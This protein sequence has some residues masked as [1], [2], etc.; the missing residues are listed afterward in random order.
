MFRKFA[1]ITLCFCLLFSFVTVPSVA[2]SSYTGA[3]NWALAELG[4]ADTQGLIP[5]VMKDG[6]F[7]FSNEIS[8][9]DFCKAVVL[10]YDQLGGE[11]NL[12][13]SNPFSDITD[14]DVIKAFNAGIIKGKSSDRFAPDDALTRQEM[15]VMLERALTAAK[16]S[17]YVPKKGFQNAYADV[18]DIAPWALSAVESMNAYKII[19]GTSDQWLSPTDHLTGE[20]AIVMMYR[21]FTAFSGGTIV[22]DDSF[23]IE[24]GVLKKCIGLGDVVIPNTVT[25]IDENVFQNFSGLTSITIPGTVKEIP[26]EAF[27]DCPDL[28]TVILQEGVETIGAWSFA[29]C[30]KLEKVTLPGSVKTIDEGAFNNCTSLSAI[31]F[32]E[33]L[34]SIGNTCFRDVSLTDVVLPASLNS[35]GDEA[36]YLC[37]KLKNVTFK[38]DTVSIGDYA[39]DEVNEDMVI[40]CGSGSTAE[41]YAD[42]NGLN[43]VVQ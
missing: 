20:Q 22:Q 8:R 7:N 10:F 5:A 21:S 13:Q 9:E 43:K 38:S 1:A 15:C 32:N 27:R 35:I 40:H 42:E 37:K 14:A 16:V 11:Q 2:G 18:K 19:N 34:Q 33:G 31:T 41:A 12:P 25:S 26:S 28:K 6:F 39:F 3:S 4:Y 29:E 17:K 36:F 23:V 24:N 30:G